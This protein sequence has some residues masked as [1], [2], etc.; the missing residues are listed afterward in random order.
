MELLAFLWKLSFYAWFS[1][2]IFFGILG[3]ALAVRLK[4]NVKIAIALGFV[5]QFLGI[6]ALV[7]TYLVSKEK[8]KPR[9]VKG[10]AHSNLDW[11]GAAPSSFGASG[12]D[13]G[14]DFGSGTNSDFTAYDMG[15]ETSASKNWVTKFPG[16]LI[17]VGVISVGVS[18]AVSMFLTWFN[19]VSDQNEVMGITA[20]ST[21]LD[22]WIFIS[23]AVLIASVLLSLKGPSL[24][25]SVLLAW[26]GS[27]WLMLSMAS[28]T[29]RA[30]FVPAIDSLFQIPNLVIEAQTRDGLMSSA[31]AFDIGPAW[32]LVFVTALLLLAGSSWLVTLANEKHRLAD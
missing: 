9:L 13:S 5:F 10:E 30:T 26:V 18:L 22:F 11:A 2:A 32:Y 25:A 14:Y 29:A 1:G 7:V 17:F 15:Y 12:I 16:L 23:I 21:G 6:I 8:D 3:A 27:W 28:L 31:Y 20:V 19:V 24:V 4:L